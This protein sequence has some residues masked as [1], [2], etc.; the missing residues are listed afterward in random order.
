MGSD[1]EGTDKLSYYHINLE[2]TRGYIAKLKYLR[3][4]KDVDVKYRLGQALNMCKYED[5][6]PVTVGG[7]TTKPSVI[8]VYPK[9]YKAELVVPATGFTDPGFRPGTLIDALRT[10]FGEVVKGDIKITRNAEAAL[11]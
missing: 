5:E 6:R 8:R 10:W 4:E 2:L 3:R 7:V 9:K 11:A 1:K